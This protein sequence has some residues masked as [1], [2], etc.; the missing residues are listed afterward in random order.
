MYKFACDCC[1]A[2]FH[3]DEIWYC[4]GC[5]T[6]L[7]TPCMQNGNAGVQ[8]LDEVGMYRHCPRMHMKKLK[9][10]EYALITVM[11]DNHPELQD[12]L[13]MILE[14]NTK[15]ANRLVSQEGM[16]YE[17]LPDPVKYAFAHNAKWL[18]YKIKALKQDSWERAPV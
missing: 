14:E 6:L 5:G 15:L 13:K 1:A 9:N 18:R 10:R 12:Y 11:M 7:C 2:P 8:F 16:T 3:S 17:T 4:I